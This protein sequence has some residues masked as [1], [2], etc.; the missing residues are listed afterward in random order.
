MD[1]GRFV[2]ESSGVSV[3]GLS[4]LQR[5]FKLLSVSQNTFTVGLL[6]HFTSNA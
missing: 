6:K 1:D 5:S 2:F 3:S 4:S